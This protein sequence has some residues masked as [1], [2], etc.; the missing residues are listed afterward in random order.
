MAA[1]CKSVGFIP[2]EVRILDP[3]PL[4]GIVYWLIILAF[5]ASEVG[6]IP[7]TRSTTSVSNVFSLKLS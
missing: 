6:S 4:A 1:D 5:Q 7:T 2:T 3:G